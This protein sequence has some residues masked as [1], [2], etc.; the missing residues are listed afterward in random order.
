MALLNNGQGDQMK[1][2]F[3]I[4]CNSTTKQTVFHL[5]LQNLVA[6]KQKFP[7]IS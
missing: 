4:D 3:I 7:L 1:F 2:A 5:F 6:I